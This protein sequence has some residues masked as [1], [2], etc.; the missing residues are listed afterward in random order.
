VGVWRRG[1]SWGCGSGRLT[2]R[3]A[4]HCSL[5]L[6]GWAQVG[7]ALMRRTARRLC[8]LRLGIRR[9]LPLVR[10][11]PHSAIPPC[12]LGAVSAGFMRWSSCRLRGQL[13]VRISA[14]AFGRSSAFESIA[15][16]AS[17]L[18]VHRALPL[19]ALFGWLGRRGRGVRVIGAESACW[20]H[21]DVGRLVLGGLGVS[22][23][24]ERFVF[25]LP[26]WGRLAVRRFGLLRAVLSCSVPASGRSDAPRVLR[27]PAP[28]STLTS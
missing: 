17:G 15:Y 16:W 3:G 13:F 19:R 5:G 23:A 1:S 10:H 6:T 14:F 7:S 21:R 12:R 25:G 8:A 2:T 4:P 24:F 27:L 28:T 22:S 18:R 11:G 26:H 9:P 20:A